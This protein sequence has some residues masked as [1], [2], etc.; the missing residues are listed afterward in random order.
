MEFQFLIGKLTTPGDWSAEEWDEMFQFLIGKLTT[1]RSEK[2]NHLHPQFQFL[3]G[4]LT[5]EPL[6]IT[7]QN[8]I[9]VSIPYR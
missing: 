5:T 4:K 8:P 1:H 7:F 2:S 3:I 6:H 9:I